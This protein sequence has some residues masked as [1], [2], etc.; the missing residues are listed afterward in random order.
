MKLPLIRTVTDV[1]KAWYLQGDFL[2]TV[3]Y[4]SFGESILSATRISSLY[5]FT[6]VIAGVILGFIVMKVRQLKPFIVS[7]TVLF[8]VAFGILNYYRGGAGD[9]SHS[10]VIGGQIL[11]GIGKNR[12]R[13]S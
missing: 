12:G 11:L 13:A 9:S 2:Y 10:G 8:M 4:V 3:L 7:G 6:S 5:S 1:L